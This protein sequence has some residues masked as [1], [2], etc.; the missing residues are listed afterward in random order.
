MD[1]NNLIDEGNQL[2]NRETK[3]KFLLDW[4]KGK[5][6]KTLIDYEKTLR[7]CANIEKLYDKDLVFFELPEFE[8]LLWDF[9][10]TTV[11][12]LKA[13]L[14]LLKTYELWSQQQG[15]LKS[16]SLITTRFD[17]T[18]LEKY[19]YKVGSIEKF[20]GFE[21]L[22]MLMDK[23]VNAQDSVIFA[24]LYEGI[25]GV[26]NCEITNLLVTDYNN[27]GIVTIRGDKPRQIKVHDNTLKLMEQARKQINYEKT[28]KKGAGDMKS[29]NYELPTG[30]SYLIRQSPKK[31]RK[32]GGERY[33]LYNDSSPA[34]WQTINSRVKKI[35]MLEEINRPYLTA[36]SLLQSG[37]LYKV[38][39]V[40]TEKGKDRL[41]IDDFKYIMVQY[42]GKANNYFILK[43]MYET[44]F[45]P[46]RKLEYEKLEE[47]KPS[48]ISEKTRDNFGENKMIGL[49]YILQIRGITLAK[50]GEM[51]GVSKQGVYKWTSGSN[52]LPVDRLKKFS[53][54]LKVSEDLIVEE[55][56]VKLKVKILNNEI[57]S[58]G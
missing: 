41:T 2:Y 16:K 11:R 25:K 55:L 51:I 44:V 30:S 21:E 31:S 23:V 14:N 28:Q 57:R 49:S 13:S 17:K 5:S 50:A 27:D 56:D 43:E 34:N 10:S 54:L 15:Y 9:K 47:V 20:I 8:N 42:G 48:K 33:D 32:V 3:I 37:M 29:T 4:C 39:E 46:I 36:H 18:D 24:L 19:L 38:L 40:E 53:E 58:V 52:K 12:S 7:I 26:N 1:I 45:E 6:Q 22:F 35:A